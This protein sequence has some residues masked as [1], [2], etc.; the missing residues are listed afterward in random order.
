ME[1]R[2]EAHCHVHRNYFTYLHK[3]NTSVITILSSIKRAEF[4]L[5]STNI[6]GISLSCHV[7]YSPADA[8]WWQ[9][10]STEK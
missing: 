4:H 2:L 5:S 10:A 6:S 9:C 7:I 1:S 3:T 8:H